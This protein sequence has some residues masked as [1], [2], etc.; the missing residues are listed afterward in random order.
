MLKSTHFAFSLLVLPLLF[1]ALVSGT[2]LAQSQQ[3]WVDTVHKTFISAY[4][5]C[6]DGP[7]S[8]TVTT[9]PTHGK[10][11]FDIEDLS[12]PYPS[13][14]TVP[15]AVAR[16][17]WTD[18]N[19]SVLQ[20]PFTLVWSLEGVPTIVTFSIIGELAK[21]KTGSIWWVC[22]VSGGSL[23]DTGKLTLDNPPSY[24]TSFVWTITAGATKL[25]FS[26]GKATIETTGNKAGVKTLAPSAALDDISVNVV[27]PNGTS[28]PSTAYVKYKASGT[29]MA[30]A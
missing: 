23:R 12:W 13:C 9:A 30:H 27:A 11:F 14:G 18:A 16:Y 15:S 2:A 29:R 26:N 21:I 1:L 3:V 10:L 28:W 22:G 25:V 17:T 19:E 5:A 7:G 6:S 4:T 24:S 20:D 8:F